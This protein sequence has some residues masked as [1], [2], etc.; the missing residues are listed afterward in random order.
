M[1][2]S[3]EKVDTATLMMAGIDRCVRALG[4]DQGANDA[5]LGKAHGLRAGLLDGLRYPSKR[6]KSIDAADFDNLLDAFEAFGLRTIKAIEHDL[7][8][9]RKS[10]R[11][12]NPML[13][14]AACHLHGLAREVFGEEAIAEAKE[15][16]ATEFAASAK[17]TRRNMKR[18]TPA[19]V[20][21][22]MAR[23]SI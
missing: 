14:S 23:R 16:V 20:V 3:E 17:P 15:S 8:E 1:V 21:G 18:S 5:R 4:L 13:F 11:G 10:R 12:P 6:P 22:A 2:R 7:D 19:D 9:A